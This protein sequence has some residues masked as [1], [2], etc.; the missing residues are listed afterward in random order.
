MGT[1][2]GISSYTMGENSVGRSRSGQVWERAGEGASSVG[3]GDSWCI[4]ASWARGGGGG[5]GSGSG[6]GQGSILH[7][8]D[9]FQA[10]AGHRFPYL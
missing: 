1:G 5:T 10:L 6:S 2:A 3:S 4:G 9:T 7:L 8:H